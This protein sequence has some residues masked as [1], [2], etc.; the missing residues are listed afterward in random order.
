MRIIYNQDCTNLFAITKEPLTPAH[1]DQMVDEVAD[2]GA[3]VMLINPNAQRV[4]YPSQVWQTF[5]DGFTPDD[6]AFLGPVPDEQ[7]AGRMAWVAQMQRLAD[8]GCDYLA[9]ALARCREKGLTPGVT[10]RMND[11]HDVPWPGSHLFSAF[12]LAHPEWRLRNPD[13]CGWGATGLNY[14]YPS[15]RAH[16]LALIRELVTQYEFEVLELDFLRFQCYFPREDFARHA[17]I[18]TGFLRDVRALLAASGRKIELIPR[19][20][21]SPAAAYEQGFDVAQWARDGLIDGLTTGAFLNTNWDIPVEEFRAAMGDET[22]LYI[23]ADV[24]IERVSD[25]PSRYL[26]LY[27]DFLRG[28]AA[29]YHAAGADGLNFFNFFCTREKEGW[30]RED[31]PLFAVLRELRAPAELHGVSKAY[32]LTANSDGGLRET[33]RPGQAPVVISASRRHDFHLLLAAEPD[34]ARVTVELRL[35]GDTLPEPTQL[36]LHVNAVMTGWAMEVLALPDSANM[37]LARFAVPAR[38]LRDGWNRLMLCNE[39]ADITVHGLDVRVEGGPDDATR[40]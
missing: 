10:V 33:D 27:P 6:R 5:W 4:N 18:M 24:C 8:A 7:V 17:G 19:V 2:G 34:S 13:I 3:E 37:A 29:G 25:P 38:A 15:V 11:M 9:R 39:G 40:D 16:Y 30:G 12:Y 22:P 14:E 32:A 31:D 35:K 26:P 20:P 23:G 1:V 36:W 21:T 28:F